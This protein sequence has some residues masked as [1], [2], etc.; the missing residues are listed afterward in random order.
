MPQNPPPRDWPRISSSI[1]YQDA[2]KAIDW[3][4]RAFGFEVRLRIEDDAGTIAHS[5]LCYGDGVIMVCQEGKPAEDRI[6]KRA[7][8]SP[9]G[10]NKK[11]SQ[12]LMVYVDDVDRHC[13]H[14]RSCG[15][16][17]VDEPT[18]HDYGTDYWTDRSYG[19]LDCEG[20]LWW[21]TQ[22]VRTGNI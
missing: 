8:A 14:A 12:S 21:I 5:E 15:A 7:M 3:L 6:W 20:H 13:A 4:T 10:L 2:A 9:L 1:F 22:R 19:A 16:E 18:T 17:I 11:N